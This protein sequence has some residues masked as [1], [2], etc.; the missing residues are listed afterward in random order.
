[1]TFQ[2]LDDI[3]AAGVPVILPDTCILLDILRSPRRKSVDARLIKSAKSIVNAVKNEGTAASVIANQVLGELKKN[4]DNV[5]KE[6]EKELRNLQREILRIN[7]W[8]SA[9][10]E[11]GY[12][13]ISHGLAAVSRCKPI[14][15]DWVDTSIEEPTT[16]KL[17]GSAHKRMMEQKTPAKSGK[18]SFPDCLI[19]ET[20][21]KFASDFRAKNYK[22][23]IIFAS[24]N[25]AEF[26][27]K[28]CSELHPG[29]AQEFDN[30]GIRYARA[31][32]E[33]AHYLGLKF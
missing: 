16:D 33:A 8:S 22:A 27:K 2:S 24:S 15:S 29:I 6:T 10:G 17:T 26:V 12:A 21:L 4:Q 9:L 7:G 19:V 32:H 31:L 3:G 25:T 5:Q 13:D 20:Y 28:A 14:L 30:V 18:D 23:P 1:M 11:V